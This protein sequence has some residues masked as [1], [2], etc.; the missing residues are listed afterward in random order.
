MKSTRSWGT[1]PQRLVT[2]QE[3]IFIFIY[4]VRLLLIFEVLFG[5]SSQTTAALSQFIGAFSPTTGGLRYMMLVVLRQM[6]LVVLCYTV[7]VALRHMMLVVVR[8][9]VLPLWK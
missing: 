3:I 2:C 9:L 5:R 7:L 8:L 4:N 1:L 6:V